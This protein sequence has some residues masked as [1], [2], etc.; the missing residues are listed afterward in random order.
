MAKKPAS[1]EELLAQLQ[2]IDNSTEVA[3]LKADVSTL[4]EEKASLTGQRDELQKRVRN[5]E[6]SM[7]TIREA[8]RAQDIT[9]RPLT[10]RLNA[11]DAAQAEASRRFD[12]AHVQ[13]GVANGT[14]DPVTG[15]EFTDETRP[16]R[17]LSAGSPKVS[18]GE[19]ERLFPQL[20]GSTVE[21][22]DADVEA[23]IA[24]DVGALTAKEIA[25]G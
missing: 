16:V 19:L 1:R 9:N 20:G 7:S 18:K 17:D 6:K 2:A 24:A 21:M 12:L 5:L 25:G 8:V 4:T 23:S 13:A 3:K 10:N 22:S 14:H 15:L 11:D